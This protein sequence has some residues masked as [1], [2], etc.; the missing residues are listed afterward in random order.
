MLHTIQSL[1][2][3]VVGNDLI[4]NDLLKC[5]YIRYYYNIY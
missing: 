4:N 2:S 3:Q 5:I 1:Y